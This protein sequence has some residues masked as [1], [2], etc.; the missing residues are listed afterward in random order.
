MNRDTYGDFT[1]IYKQEINK[2]FSMFPVNIEIAKDISEFIKY[3]KSLKKKWYK[4]YVDNFMRLF[5]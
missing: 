2:S 4:V 3:K 5:K 1:F